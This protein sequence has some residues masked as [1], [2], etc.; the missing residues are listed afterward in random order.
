MRTPGD[1]E[2]VLTAIT[3]ALHTIALPFFSCSLCIV[4][5]HTSTTDVQFWATTQQGQWLKEHYQAA[6]DHPVLAF[7]QADAPVYRPDLDADDPFN[8]KK[9]IRD[10]YQK[11]IRC[12]LDVP[13]AFG[14]LSLASLEAHAFSDEHTRFLQAL[15]PYFEDAINRLKDLEALQRRNQEL[16][17]LNKELDNFSSVASHDLKSPLRNII[18]FSGLLEKKHATNTPEKNSQYIRQIV[19]QSRRMQELLEHLLAYARAG[20]LNKPLVPVDLSAVIE[21]TLDTLAAVVE[22]CKAEITYGGLPVVWGEPV[23]LR[24]LFQNLVENGLKYQD[25]DKGT[26]KVEITAAQAGDEWHIGVKD[27]GIGMAPEHLAQIFEPFKRLHA[28]DEYAGSGLGLATCQKIAAYHAGRIWVE[29]DLGKGTTFYCA[30]KGAQAG[31]ID[32]PAPV[33]GAGPADD[34]SSLRVLLAEDDPTNQM[35]ASAMLH[36]MGH[37]VQTAATG[38]EALHLF[39]SAGTAFHVL[40]LDMH[41]PVASG[42][43]VTRSIR[44]REEKTGKRVPIIAL[45]GRAEEEERMFL[46]MGFDGYLAKPV[47]AEKLQAM[48]RRVLGK[49]R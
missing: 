33:G 43:E 45:T 47:E 14:T 26:P 28:Q 34:L 32:E 38:E 36:R 8:E 31:D 7:M 9:G 3:E 17:H 18:L 4:K 13:Y 42:E 2:H 12:L 48:L 49:A 41:M 35:V 27:N 21:F 29:S 20:H 16:E 10:G 23:S 19:S 25:K 11:P 37:Q 15:V 1:L 40:I 6:T 39:H 5:P 30:L 22:E 24:Q 46:T 44:S